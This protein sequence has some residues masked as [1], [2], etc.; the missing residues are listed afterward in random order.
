MASKEKKSPHQEDNSI[1]SELIRRFK[2]NPFIFIGTIVILVI[3]IVA[4]VFVPAIVPS[5]GGLGVDLRFGAYNKTPIS[6][7]PNGY[8]AQVREN[9]ARYR[10]SSINDS[11]YQVVLYQIWRE[12]F[13]ETVIHTGILDEMKR[14]G[15]TPPEE[16]VDREVAQLP[17]FQENGRFSVSTYRALDNTTRIS[18][19]RQ[20]QENVIKNRYNEDV[21]DLKISSGETDF[22]G[23]MASP[24]RS[25]DM[26]LLPLSSYP[27][28][29]VSAYAANNAGLF[30]VTHLSVITVGSGEQE[31][32]KIL[33]SIK[34]GTSTFEDAART[35]SQD[36]YAE[37]GGDMG[38][39]MA[40]ELSTEIPEAE[41]RGK[42]IGTPKGEYTSI[43]KVPSGWAFFR[44]EDASY[45]AD[46]GDP[47][48]LEKIR[49]YMTT[50][51]R[52]RIEDWLI[53]DARNLITL[54]GELGFDEALT[55]KALEKRSFGPL[56]LNYGGDSLYYNGLSLF[57]ALASFSVSELSSADTNENFWR[58][59]FSTPLNT[60]SN[61]LVLGN[62][63]AVLYPLE[64]TPEDEEAIDTIKTIY[65]SYWL[66]YITNTS[67][68]SY[69]LQSDK[70]ED[71]FY[72][73]FVKYILPTE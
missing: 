34:D 65:S 59:A 40:Y 47:A 56:A 70:L 17:Q 31:A 2:A 71:R 51:E 39:K 60:P 44:A 5:A 1:Q 69:F 55:Q 7:V 21:T 64:E 25:F 52:G 53:E 26:A 49:T 41:E 19:W 72:E 48:S 67:L 33:D 16:V 54:T 22:I 38:I 73:T 12:A 58:E 42:V 15:Y 57:T 9:I 68:R 3:V 20:M 30:R 10:Q 27:D 24:K 46:P 63:V 32:Q 13:E 29:E 14:A 45:P 4:F 50:F 61:P 35:Y 6:F 66:S 43:V 37:R 11:N 8:F 36:S 18:L 28:T 23:A 62:Y